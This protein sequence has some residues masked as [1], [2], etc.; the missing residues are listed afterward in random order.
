MTFVIKLPLGIPLHI[1][2]VRHQRVQCD[3]LTLA[4]SDNLRISVALET[5][6]HLFDKNVMGIQFSGVT[7]Q[8]NVKGKN[9]D[10]GNALV[11]IPS[12]LWN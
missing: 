10:Y 3:D 7:G 5:P 9:A 12:A 11:H 8:W 6:Q 1:H 2:P 4:V